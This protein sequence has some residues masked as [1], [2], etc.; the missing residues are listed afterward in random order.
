MARILAVDDDPTVL[1]MVRLCLTRAHYAVDVVEGCASA[2]AMLKRR[3]Y[4][5]LI[6]DVNMPTSSGKELLNHCRS[7]WPALEVILMTGQPVVRDAVETVRHGAYDYLVKPVS[8]DVLLK[9]VA[10]A[11]QRQHQKQA[12]VTRTVALGQMVRPDLKIIRTLGVGSFGMVMLA[13]KDGRSYALKMLK[14]KVDVPPAVLQRFA[15]EAEIL[16]KIDHPNIVRMIDYSFHP[17]NDTPYILMEYAEGKDLSQLVGTDGLDLR[18]KLRIL[19]QIAGALAAVHEKGVVHRD[20][21]PH[22][23][24]VSPEYLVKLTDFGIARFAA[25]SFSATNPDELLGSPVYMA[26]ESFES[27]DLV[28]A[29]SDVFSLGVLSYELI[30]G[31]RPFSGAGLPQVMYAISNEPFPDPRRL[32]PGL[33]PEVGALLARMLEKKPARRFQTAAQA[34]AAIGGA[35]A[36]LAR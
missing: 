28:D 34:A 29:R 6:T 15:R 24:M 32:V 17:S 5:L 33:P 7:E 8:P 35:L 14:Q 30:T 2:L 16:S 4:Q 22:N 13:E 20:V 10:E 18:T 25:S 9:T 12:Y 11:L 31:R 36:R 1:A 3:P 27:A 21:K 26:P 19:R 23:V